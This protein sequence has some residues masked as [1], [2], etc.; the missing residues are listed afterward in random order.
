MR[1]MRG[2][3]A[4]P[5]VGQGDGRGGN[6]AAVSGEVRGGA[7]VSLLTNCQIMA[8]IRGMETTMMGKAAKGDARGVRVSLRKIVAYRAELVRREWAAENPGTEIQ[9]VRFGE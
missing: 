5:V 9:A 2:D 3:D 8:M 6:D 1:A 7:G 4:V